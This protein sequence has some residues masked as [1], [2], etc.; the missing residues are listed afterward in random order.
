MACN[1]DS[2]LDQLA[3]S[4]GSTGLP[5]DQRKK[6]GYWNDFQNLADELLDF[7]RM[8][9][10]P[11]VMPKLSE[12]EEAGKAYLL[13]P[14]RNFGG[15]VVVAD[16]L[17]MKD[18]WKHHRKSDIAVLIDRPETKEEMATTIAR[19]MQCNISLVQAAIDWLESKGDIQLSLQKD[20]L[21]QCVKFVRYAIY[22][23]KGRFDNKQAA[24]SLKI[25]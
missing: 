21:T 7:A 22:V 3:Q 8:Q 19:K 17:S 13:R 4:L 20:G 23:K 25:D 24:T 11:D 6:A 10:T 15:M 14:I 18:V 12:L 9:G 5:I 1:A 2:N 16:R